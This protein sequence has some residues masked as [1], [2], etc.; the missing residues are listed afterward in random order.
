M[1][2]TKGLGRLYF[3]TM[4]LAAGSPFLHTAPTDELDPPF[5][6]GR[7]LVIRL[8]KIFDRSL[9]KH[10]WD[11][12]AIVVGIWTGKH[13]NEEAAVSSALQG[14]GMDVYDEEDLTDPD[15]AAVIRDNIARHTSDVDEEWTILSHLGVQ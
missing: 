4:K 11:Y 3:H 8:W 9:R 10:E 1:A 14:W 13:P 12:R 7:G 15:I 2:E 6:K 5:R